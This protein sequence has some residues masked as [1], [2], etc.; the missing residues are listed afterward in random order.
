MSIFGE[1][2]EGLQNLKID[3]D[4]N[5]EGLVDLGNIGN[6]CYMTTSLQ[7]LSNS[8]MFWRIIFY[9]IFIFNLS[10]KSYKFKRENC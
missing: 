7:C 3:K 2:K 4:N 6:T 9:M 10:N 5:L 8:K 1:A